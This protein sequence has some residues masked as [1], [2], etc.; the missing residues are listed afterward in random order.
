[1]DNDNMTEYERGYKDG[2][3]DG[4]KVCRCREWLKGKISDR[5]THTNEVI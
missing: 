2:Y 3:E 4:K 1:M 5:K